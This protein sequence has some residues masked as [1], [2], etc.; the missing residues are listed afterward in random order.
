MSLLSRIA[1]VARA[2]TLL[3]VGV[4]GWVAAQDDVSMLGRIYGTRPPAAY[5]E[6]RNRVDGAF[7][8]GRAWKS[9]AGRLTDPRIAPPSRQAQSGVSVPAAVLG[10][11]D[12][13]V[14][15]TFRFPLV[16]GYFGDEAGPPDF[17]VA[18]V[19]REFFDGP[20]SRYKTIPEYYDEVS[21]G[22]VVL[23]GDAFGWVQ[24]ELTRLE[25]TAGVSALGGLV[26][27]FIHQLL[28]AADDGSVDWGQYDNDGP[29]GVPDSGDDDGF[30]D[31]LAVFHPTFGGECG[32]AGQADRVWAHKWALSQAY[33]TIP[34]SQRPAEAT[35]ET[36]SV[37]ASG[38]RIRIDD[39]TIQPVLSCDETSINEI[40]VLAHELG[41]GFGLPD[42][43]CT[44]TGCV[45]GGIGRWG[46]M[47]SGSWGCGSFN[48]SRPCH[49]G[50]WSKSM[51]GWADVVT[52][53]PS[54]DHGVR[55]LEAV[56]S[57][58][59]VFR[60]D[61]EDGSD[62]Y[63][64]LENRQRVGFDAELPGTGL[65][66]WHV[67]PDYVLARWPT[68]SVNPEPNQGRHLGVRVRQADGRFD[69]EG[70]VNR[71]D[72]GDPFPGLRG[73]QVFH[74][75]SAPQSVTHEGRAAGVTLT[76]I[77]EVGA[78]VSFRAVTG[79]RTITLGVQG[80]GTG[81][82]LLA[83][84]EPVPLEGL[85]LQR[86]PFEGLVLNAAAGESLGEGI[87]RPF[88]GWS[89]APGMERVRVFVTP[90]QSDASVSAVYGGEEVRL[91]T[92]L[93]GGILGVPPGTIATTPPSTDPWI[94]AGEPVSL[95]AVPAD[96]YAFL[97][98][99][100]EWSG[101]PNPFS[102]TT[103]A[104]LTVGAGFGLTFSSLAYALALGPAGLDPALRQALDGFGN[105]NG[106]YDIGDLRAYL[107]RGET[108][109]SASSGSAGGGR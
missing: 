81:G 97:G 66:V 93:E 96:G 41:H 79:R 90:L 101:R 86:A 27:L 29:D 47:G 38:Q 11:R 15:G 53:P 80:A 43:Y 13:T 85:A 91:E 50:A 63:Y 95:R 34:P 74:A 71:S 105:A 107:R 20:N 1:R 45:S 21:G 32:G 40:G 92:T 42:L 31:I 19:Q 60:L 103:V 52:L 36:S 28:E 25:T 51:L 49:L 75:G 48:P 56:E 62:E 23:G 46:L 109:L 54:T 64:L 59:T 94:P 44:T 69:I 35:F 72:A 57:S 9:R 89:D 55:T 88:A 77:D 22:R 58:G 102:V 14:T 6:L 70:G 61:A 87:R 12:G 68:N 26:G 2:A 17:S 33:F 83:D 106:R 16:L 76:E 67:D 108:P 18:D 8:F 100:G 7:E 65:L 30:V 84:D 99:L 78:T 82:L 39:Y 104:P 98:W 5:I 3:S 4:P 24:S 73:T 37:S 10:Q